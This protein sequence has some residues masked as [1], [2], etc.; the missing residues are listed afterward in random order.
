MRA[1]TLYKPDA[2]H[3]LCTAH[4]KIRGCVRVCYWVNLNT[5][6]H[7][8]NITIPCMNGESLNIIQD[9]LRQ[10]EQLFPQAFSEGTLDIER[11][12]ALFT[13]DISINNERYVLNWA[14]K[15]D[16]F[17]A[18]QVPTTA[19]LQPQPAESVNFDDSN[20]IF[21]EGENLEVLKVLQKSYYGKVKCIIIDPP[22]NTGSDSFIYPDSFKE[23]K[24]DYQK[25][26]GDRDEEGNILRQS[27][28]RKNTKDSGHY[29]SNWLSM[30][31]PRLF[32]AKNLLRDDG[33]IFVHIDDN[34]VHNLRLIMNEIFGEENFVAE[35]IWK[36][37]QN[38]DN[39]NL[40][41]ASI[42]HEY[43]LCYGKRIR[44]ADRKIEQYK[45]PDNDSRG[46][47]TSGNMVGL[48]PPELRPNC[49][50]DLI[51]PNTGINYGK[52]K[53]GWRYD[54]NTMG[55]LIAENRIIFPESQDG[56]P[57]RKVFLNEITEKFTGFS[58][59]IGDKIFTRNGTAEIE[60]FFS[61]RAF[62]FPKPSILLKELIE[63]GTDENDIVL[64]FFAGSASTAQAV[65]E[66]NK[67]DGGN[68]TFILVQLPELCDE[69]SEAYKAGYRTIADIS[70]ERIRRVIQRIEQRRTELTERVQYNQERLERM[71]TQLAEL[72]HANPTL[73]TG[74][75]PPEAKELLK[76][77]EQRT[78][79]ITEHTEE[80]EKIQQTDLG[81]KAFT[82]TPSNFKIWRSD[83]I[84]QENI[85]EQLDAFANP[86]VEGSVDVNIVYELLLKAGYTLTERIEKRDNLYLVRGGEFILATESIN[87]Q[88][89]ERIIELHPQRVVALDALFNG[90]DQL[91]TNTVLQLR[92]AGIEFR[93][94]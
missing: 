79:Q 68:R 38:K 31:Y 52:P 82:C 60:D 40:T 22:Y 44:G 43:V 14:G 32:L 9:N 67:E 1:R 61:F 90:N 49:H 65:L 86:V 27:N 81:F 11:F 75:P 57:R 89:I 46:P 20:N 13:E 48:L 12:K 51:N 7:H 53:L 74:T 71:Q 3:T 69:Q 91:K 78:T 37:R 54:K 80:L 62:D 50:Y 42:D 39:R 16:A 15:S 93:T 92:D 10:L 63:Q 84:T 33:V 24:A 83:D 8:T 88:T 56:R 77:I 66:L 25:R 85:A 28:F 29:H 19:T 58:S 30:M 34:E 87:T 72:H 73:L 64:D 41:G 18:L 36:S 76:E 55:R 5:A 17:K 4:P 47:W 45:N 21:I 2:S 94:V 26:I 59:I 23:N 35:F 70:K 6:K